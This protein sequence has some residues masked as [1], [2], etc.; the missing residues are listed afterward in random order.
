MEYPIRINKYLAQNDVCS[1]REA[2]ILIKEGSVKI[3]GKPAKLGDL[4][5]EKDE[6]EVWQDKDYLY[7]A[8]NK[9]KGIITHSPQAGEKSIADI[10]S[11]P[12]KVFPLG[13]L[14][15]DSNGLILLTNDGRITDKL[16]NPIH[17]H[18]KEYLVK[19]DKLITESFIRRM[20]KG[21]LLDNGYRTKECVIKK[22]NPNSFVIVLTEGKKRQ[23]RRMCERLG[24]GVLE[25]KRTRI[26]NITLGNL[27]LGT[28]RAV[29]KEELKD[30]LKALKLEAPEE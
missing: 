8:F 5:N 20:A 19:V 1:R 27:K 11:L 26:M 17:G 6:I 13:R 16:L 28:F 23:I 4:V 7:Y 18:E 12:D 9:P 2:D 22:R 25:L 24:F 14:D 3:N 10:V 15:K 21:V 30:F 29:K